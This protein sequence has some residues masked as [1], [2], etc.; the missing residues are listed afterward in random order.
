M[1]FDHLKARSQQT[2]AD[3]VPGGRPSIEKSPTEPGNTDTAPATGTT[4]PPATQPAASTA[5][6]EASPDEPTARHWAQTT[7]S[8]LSG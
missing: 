6:S 4:P 5:A 7:V 1:G 3:A 8:R 2:R